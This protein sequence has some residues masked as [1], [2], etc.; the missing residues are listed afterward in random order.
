MNKI[1][2]P[3][4]WRDYSK[5]DVVR[6]DAV[7]NKPNAHTPSSLSARW[8]RS[9]SPWIAAEWDMSPPTVDAYYDP[10][11]NN[12]N[13]PAGYSQPPF[14]SDKEDDAA[15]YGDMGSTIG[16]ELTHG[17]D[18]EGRQYDKNGNLNDW[19]TKAD[20]DITSITAPNAW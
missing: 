17:F 15:N 1:G 14:F 10:Q 4:K 16:H 6:G 19:W 7:G 12:V 8:P 2:Y 18:D 11:Q 5:L 3:D 13:F 9:A 20:E